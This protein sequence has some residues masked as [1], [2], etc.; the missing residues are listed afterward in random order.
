MND[1]SQSKANDGMATLIEDFKDVFANE[2]PEGV[3][4]DRNAFETIPIEPNS[5]PPFR[6][7]L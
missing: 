1:S 5:E 6:H 7:M 4:Q 2:L 3:P